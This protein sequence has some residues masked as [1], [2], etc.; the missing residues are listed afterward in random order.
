MMKRYHYNLD[1]EHLINSI[2]D[3]ER[4]QYNLLRNKVLLSGDPEVVETFYKEWHGEM[5]GKYT[6]QA[7]YSTFWHN[8]GP[9]NARVFFGVIKMINDTM[10]KLVTNG[11]VEAT[12]SLN[13]EEVDEKKKRLDFILKKNN[14]VNKQ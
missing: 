12:V 10:I 8:V 9:R 1:Y 3:N 11:G 13:G 4:F 6:R 2:E 14:F 7:K 5:E